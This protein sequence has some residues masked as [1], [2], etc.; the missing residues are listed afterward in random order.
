MKR[1]RER[2]RSWSCLWILVVLQ[3]PKQAKGGMSAG[4]M[5]KRQ[6]R[7]EVERSVVFSVD[8]F[9]WSIS[10]PLPLKAVI[11]FAGDA[12][13]SRWG[14]WQILSFLSPPFASSFS[15]QVHFTGL[16]LLGRKQVMWKEGGQVQ[17]PKERN[18]HGE[19]Y[20]LFPHCSPAL[21]GS[22]N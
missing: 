6:W 22:L 5:L 15:P 19:N 4:G 13:S 8:P 11:G 12:E 21:S 2:G 3:F 9:S 20:G 1:S 14:F 17:R 7:R 10:T 18:D 16:P